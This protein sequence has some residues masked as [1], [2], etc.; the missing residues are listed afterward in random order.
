MVQLKKKKNTKLIRHVLPL[1]K[2]CN[3]YIKQFFIG[4]IYAQ[5]KSCISG[6]QVT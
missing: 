6:A 4:K 2:P 3:F 1:S 5:F